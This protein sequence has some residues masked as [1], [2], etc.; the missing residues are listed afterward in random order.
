MDQKYGWNSLDD[1]I[2]TTPIE[3]SPN[4]EA[5]D[6]DFNNT[7][8]LAKS[9]WET[10]QNCAQNCKFVDR[11][12]CYV[13]PLQPILSSLRSLNNAKRHQNDCGLEGTSKVAECGSSRD[14]CESAPRRLFNI[15]GK[16][17]AFL[18]SEINAKNNYVCFQRVLANG[19][20][21]SH[22]A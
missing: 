18:L 19:C 3:F 5:C 7:A 4:I 16:N 10:F 20:K 22:R 8:I 17:F 15:I 2:K 12:S 13:T 9:P 1:K 14:F 11:C 6:N 21:K